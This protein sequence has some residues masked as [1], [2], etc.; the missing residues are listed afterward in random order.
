MKG[1]YASP[2]RVYLL[3]GAL[4]LAGVFAGGSLPISLFPNSTKPT[5][6]LSIAYGSQTSE[7]FLN[8]FGRSL[9]S[10]LRSIATKDAKVEKLEAD[11]S[12]NSVNYNVEFHWGVDPNTALREVQNTANG[13]LARLPQESRDSVNFWLRNRNS[14]FFAASF[15][16]ETRD[17]DS[18][19]KMLE[20][21]LTPRLLRVT[22]AA[23]PTL[24]NPDEKEIKIDL[25]PDTLAALQIIPRDVEDAILSSLSSR[26]GGVISTGGSMLQIQM[27]RQVANLQ[28]LG[29]LPIPTATG[30]VHL[31]EI[32]QVDYGPRSLGSQIFKTNGAASLIVFASPKPGGNV[33]KMS[34]DILAIMEEIKPQL[35]SDVQYRVLVDPSEFIRS[36]VNNVLHEVGI[37]AL[38]AV[39][40]LFLFIGSFRNVVTA[41]IEIPLSMVLAFLLM[42]LAGMNLNLISLGGLALAAGMN[43]DA[44]VVVMENIFRHFEHSPGPHTPAGRLAIVVEAVK[45][46]R[47]AVIASTIAS[48]VVFLP[49]TFTSDLSYAILG[50]LAL[51]VVF[52]HGF[53]AIV[54]LILVPTIRL[55]LMNKEGGA[56]VPHSPIEKQL[57]WLETTYG[58]LLGGFIRHSTIK[59]SVYAG[60]SAI[61]ILLLTV[62]LPRLPKE[63]V[64]TPDTDWMVLVK[65]TEGNTLLKH[66]EMA[67]GE[68]ERDLLK[69]FGKDIQYTFTQIENPNTAVVMARLKDKSKMRPIWKAMEA[70]F[71][72]TPTVTF[73]VG[74]WNPS[75][76]PLPNPPHMQIAVRGTKARDRAYTAQA[77]QDL[78]QEKKAFPRIS[79]TPN[80]QRERSL[81][82]DVHEEQWPALR[83]AGSRITPG[84]LPELLRVATTGK[85]IGF[86]TIDDRPT[87]IVMR[88]PPF[89]VSTIEDIESLAIGITGKLVPL[90]AMA[91]V[92]SREAE[93]SIFRK[94]EREV[95][96]VEGRENTGEEGK[97]KVDLAKAQAAVAEWQKNNK[98]DVSVTFEEA[99]IDL[100]TAIN[101]LSWAVGVSI[102][103]IFLVMLLQFGTVAEPVLVLVS[104]PLGFIGVLVSLFVFG[105][106]LSLNSIL[107][108]IL[109]NGIAV[110]N[111]IL[112]VDF[113]KRLAESGLEPREAAIE[114]AQKR[115]RPI[116][117]TSLTTVLGML[118]IALGMGEGGRILQPL[119]IAVSGGLWVSMLLTLFLVPALHVSYLEW[120]REGSSW[121]FRLPYFKGRRA[122]EMGVGILFLLLP[123]SGHA[124]SFTEAV[125][126]IVERNPNVAIQKSK[127]GAVADRNLSSRWAWL[128]TL[129]LEASTGKTDMYGLQSTRRGV[130][131]NASFNLFK[132]G[133]DAAAFS[134]ADSE[135]TAE[136]K[137][138]EDVT[139]KTESDA[140]RALSALLQAEMETATIREILQTREEALGIGQER[141]KRG[142]LAQQEVDKFSVDLDN[143]R[144]RLSD[145]EMTLAMS[146]AEVESLLGSADVEREWPWKVLLP[147][148]KFADADLRSRPD[149]SAGS[150]KVAAARSRKNEALGKLFPSLDLGMNYGYYVNSG[151][152]TEIGVGPDISGTEWSGKIAL[153]IPLFDRFENL[154]TYRASIESVRMAEWDLEKTKRAAK[155]EVDS[156]K[157]TFQ[158]AVATAQLRDKT[159]IVSRR[160]YTDNLA[161]FKRGLVSANDLFLDQDRLLDS[162][163]NQI[164][165]WAGAHTA[166]AKLCQA[167]GKHL[168]ECLDI[169]SAE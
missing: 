72:N 19:Y 158:V 113:I 143:A 4:A 92:T 14:G 156:T 164:R 150:E 107:G 89:A 42:K 90:K 48:L 26:S 106:S 46:V 21:I 96:L 75:E 15:Y 166:F 141:Y 80:V 169:Q 121:R 95:V 68:F 44:S 136:E 138:L 16:S 110:A 126:K 118:P 57:K 77:I 108:V 23:N 88:Y 8:T 63:V 145:S 30:S 2:I 122:T 7:E 93:P 52:S 102:A 61:L 128:P 159:M 97:A 24:W 111:S 120:R 35:P 132:F 66:M 71:T 114:A 82:L 149:V 157:K 123:A 163:L 155:S 28:T 70:R 39:L 74:P 139:L 98:S 165:G 38:L 76:L 160:V 134:A 162:Q 153:T 62:V 1:L 147:K 154:G 161:R 20:P 91:S 56:S 115:L 140:V 9:E 94:D 81:V 87:D 99:D 137:L 168:E 40:V 83:A 13:M 127:A 55:H 152:P 105:S 124:M 67:A 100:T 119:G 69:E 33:K 18:L 142:L 47:F 130:S 58:R 34:E 101:Q 131:G 41:A 78:L 32:G 79:T 27:P 59:W 148:K 10:Q 54:A 36:S 109:L 64:G 12:P 151:A 129:S 22:E 37:A 112:L 6:N 116:L 133:A 25:Y 31:S 49:L 51:A 60:C 146:Q 84:D 50:D 135:V 65:T 144:A 104:V 45:E 29:D 11:Y 5:V 125:K 117:I 85:R 103:L 73:W 167:T 3:L 53:S 17:L 43:V 86:L